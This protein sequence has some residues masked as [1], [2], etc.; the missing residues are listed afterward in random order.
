M[1]KPCSKSLSSQKHEHVVWSF[2][3]INKQFGVKGK[4]IMSELS[5]NVVCQNTSDA[6]NVKHQNC[7]NHY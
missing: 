3:V 5:N 2:G 4:E 1:K 7:L 6:F